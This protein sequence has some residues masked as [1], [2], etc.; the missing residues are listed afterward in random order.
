MIAGLTKKDIEALSGLVLLHKQK[1]M[2]YTKA[3]PNKGMARRH[4]E[5]VETLTKVRA[6]ADGNRPDCTGCVRENIETV[7]KVC[8]ECVRRPALVDNFKRRQA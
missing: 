3:V 7:D 1:V 4:N 6:I 8:A 5:F 2:D